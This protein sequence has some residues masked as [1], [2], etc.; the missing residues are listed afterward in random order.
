MPFASTGVCT[1]LWS[2]VSFASAVFSDHIASPS[3]PVLRTK[4][5]DTTEFVSVYV[6]PRSAVRSGSAKSGRGGAGR[7]APRRPAPGARAQLR[8]ART[9]GDVAATGSR[10]VR[11]VHPGTVG[12]PAH[13]RTARH[14][15][16][17]PARAAR[18]RAGV[19]GAQ[20]P[21]AVPGA[22]LLQ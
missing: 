5:L 17:G 16:T 1:V 18:T 8:D 3:S 19:A 9:R 12:E 7:A 11:R 21:R 15:A 20:S 22:E 14:R 2:N 6:S 10:G 4:L 13:R